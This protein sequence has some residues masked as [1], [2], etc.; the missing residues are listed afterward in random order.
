VLFVSNGEQRTSDTLFL[1]SKN[2]DI[3]NQVV[4]LARRDYL[5]AELAFW[6][7]SFGMYIVIII[8]ISR[9]WLVKLCEVNAYP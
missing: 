3:A 4:S 5:Y 6:R 9:N 2:S 8:D 1:T 7:V